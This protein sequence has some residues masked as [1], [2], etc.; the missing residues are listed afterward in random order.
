MRQRSITGPVILV[1]IG[2][3]FLLNNLRPD[4]S[5]FALIADYWPF[6]LI[7]A[8]VIGLIEVLTAVSRGSAAP[9]RPLGGGWI[10]W[11]VLW[12]I[13]AGVLS[14]HGV[15]HFRPYD[16]GGVTLLGS[17][18]D[19]TA[20]VSGSPQAI[21]PGVTR[22]I[23]DN[24]RGNVSLKGDDS[25]EIKVAGHK[26]V[27][28]FNRSTADRADLDSRVEVE[29]KGDTM[30]VRMSSPNMSSR[31][32]INTD[33]DI[34][35][36]K[37]LS[38]EAHGRAGDLTVDNVDGSLDISSARGDVRL[39]HIGKD[40]RVDAARSGLIRASDL[41]GNI[42]LQGRGRDIQL[43]NIAGE[44]T[45]NGDF[46][47]TLEFRALAKALRFESSR[48]E[49]HVEA[50][51]GVITLDLGQLKLT[52]VSGPVRFQT[53]TRD[54]EV[55]D[56]TNALDLSVDRGD[57]RVTQSKGPLPKIDLHSHN[58][59]IDLSLPDKTGF[60]LRGTTSQGEAENEFGAP[61]ETQASGRGA[62]IQ[63]QVPSG[64]Q[65]VL[66]TDRGTISVRKL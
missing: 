62:T 2:L 31:M 3:L 49:F 37:G 27:R 21:P 12:A 65:I 30:V 24:L 17:D 47:G 56:V 55:H 25:A 20:A 48:T 34:T 13:I 36:P 51:P 40:V 61:L 44:S 28:A 8:G 50:V 42:D 26:T 9:P 1:A 54:I 66:T 6:L 53:G 59:D 46:S 33:L 11:I 15:L 39:S 18:Y 10:F 22:I 29:R 32:T 64:P 45:V 35:V 57:I 52:N 58:G 4:F 7:A 14:D 63:G 41:R 16:V 43:E 38:I 60:Q 23:L 5:P 19:Y